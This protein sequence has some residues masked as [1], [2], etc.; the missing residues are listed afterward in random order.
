MSNAYQTEHNAPDALASFASSS[1]NH[2][3]HIVNIQDKFYPFASTATATFTLN[4][5]RNR[6]YCCIFVLFI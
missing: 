4:E 5:D 6:M 1:G 3:A 2:I